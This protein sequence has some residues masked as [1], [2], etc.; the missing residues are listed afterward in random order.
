MNLE[1]I[2]TKLEQANIYHSETEILDHRSVVGYEKVFKWRWLATQ[3][4]TFIVATD[5]GDQEITDGLLAHH[6]Y[7][8]FNFADKN[9]T[10]WMRGMQ[11]GTGVISI[12]ISTNVTQEA[13]FYCINSK[14]G[15]KFAAFTIPVVV[16]ANTQEV[17][18]FHSTPMWGLIYY[19]HFRKLINSL[20]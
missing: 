14:S 1:S 7:E 19:P 17:F 15:K 18:Q 12:V 11:S 16:D 10:G 9:Y 2:K 13:K 20:K 5:F 3:L 6:L 4:N 8:S